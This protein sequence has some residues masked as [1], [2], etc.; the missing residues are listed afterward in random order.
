MRT[1]SPRT[2][3]TLERV[4]TGLVALTAISLAAS[5]V[6]LGMI[7]FYAPA[8]A[9]MGIVQKIF[10]LH[11]PSALASYLGFFLCCFASI[12]YL[13]KRSPTAD[14]VARAGAELGVLFCAIVLI[15]GPLWARKA[16]GTWWTGEPRLM[17]TLVMALI[18]V[19]YLLVRSLG[20][21]TELTRKICA[22]LAILGVAD[23]PLV[24]ISVERWRGA[25]PQVVTGEGGG[26]SPDMQIVFLVSLVSIALLFAL[27]LLLRIRTGMMELALDERYQRLS[28]VEHR[29]EA[30]SEARTSP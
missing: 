12:A 5:L 30:L 11:V 18:F 21:R 26:L 25:H 16:W 17:L 27:L 20:G 24:R 23:I 28:A 6:M 2:L 22:V 4:P 3:R 8:E 9:T 29:L 10:Y 15:T 1:P 19:A 13:I 14:V 7:F